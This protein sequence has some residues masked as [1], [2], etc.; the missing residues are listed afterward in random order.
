MAER[1]DIKNII[2][3]LMMAFPNYHPDV[4]SKPNIVDVMFDLLGD[5]SPDELQ[6]AVRYCCIEP[7][8][9]FAPG[10]GTIRNA[11]A[12]L[13]AKSS[14]LPTAGEAWA[15]VY[16]SFERMPGGNMAGGGH[17]AILDNPIVKEAVH[18]MGGYPAISVDFYEQ[19]G[20]NRTAFLKIYQQLYDRAMNDV[21]ELPAISDF[22]ETQKQIGGGVKSLV[23]KLS[24]PR[25]ETK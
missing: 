17:N 20:Y 22:I 15:A 18:Q 6:A 8:R 16:D 7:G 14:G 21:T 5:I 19:Q 25:L 10:A 3:Y 13:R 24:H 23:D 9:E 1:S 11:V 12:N 2:A 4:T